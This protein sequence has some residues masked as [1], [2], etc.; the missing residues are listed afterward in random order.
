MLVSSRVATS[1]AVCFAICDLP[2]CSILFYCL[3]SLFLFL[4][5]SLPVRLAVAKGA[6]GKKTGRT[7]GSMD[8]GI[9]G[10]VPVLILIL[11]V[12]AL[13]AWVF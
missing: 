9:L 13:T 8:L 3:C 1:F 10:P 11:R 12:I 2:G 5:F 7:I 6:G 4:H